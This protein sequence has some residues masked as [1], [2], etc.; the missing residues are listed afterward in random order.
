MASSTPN[1][2][3]ISQTAAKLWR[4]SFFQN[5]DRPPSW[6]SIQNSGRNGGVRH[7]KFIYLAILDHPRSSLMDL[8]SH[9]KFGV[10][11]TFTFEGIVIL[12]F[13]KIGLKRSF[14]PQNLR[15]W[16]FNL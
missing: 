7:F 8:K 5:G 10:N 15:F 4:F 12:K 13:C 9:R 1:L 11:R 16:G 14:R 2:V 3:K 6:I